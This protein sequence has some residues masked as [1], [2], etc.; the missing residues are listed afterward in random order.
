MNSTFRELLQNFL[1]WP[2]KATLLTATSIWGICL[3]VPICN[4]VP[5]QTRNLS[6]AQTQ[7]QKD[8]L[9]KWNVE[10]ASFGGTNGD[11]WFKF[12][13]STIYQPSSFLAHNFQ[14]GN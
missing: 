9:S 3:V 8:E 10:D 12:T 14:K 4:K 11:Y 5:T 6:M 13:C 2:Q 7:S 1:D